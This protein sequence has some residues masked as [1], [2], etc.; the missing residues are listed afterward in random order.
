MRDPYQRKSACFHMGF[1]VLLQTEGISLKYIY[2]DTVLLRG[3]PVS[4][5]QTRE[6][7]G[8]TGNQRHM[9]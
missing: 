3:V 9:A 5:S 1:L 6:P 7:E 8:G 2:K 4:C